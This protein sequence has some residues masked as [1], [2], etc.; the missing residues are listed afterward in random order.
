[1]KPSLAPAI[2]TQSTASPQRR[3]FLQWGLKLP[4]LIGLTGTLTWLGKALV[5]R[6]SASSQATE[7]GQFLAVNGWVIPEKYLK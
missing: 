3:K 6:P 2:A 4:M 7:T 5:S 1:M